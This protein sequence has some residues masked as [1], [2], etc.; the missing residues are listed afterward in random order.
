MARP[1]RS[2]QSLSRRGPSRDSRDRALVVCEGE[3]T[4]PTYFTDMIQSLNL[5]S[6]RVKILGKECGSDPKSVYHYAMKIFEED[7]GYDSLFCVFDKDKHTT[8]DAA[9][10]MIER[11]KLSKDKKIFCIKSV[12][13]FEYWLIL[14]FNSTSAPITS[15]GRRS[16]G[17]NAVLELQKHMSSYQKGASGVYEATKAHLSKAIERSKAV[18]KE[19]ILTG[20]KNPETFVH[21]L[22]EHLKKMAEVK[23]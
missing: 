10:E 2:S 4:E 23:V 15:A 20:S 21:L 9:C 5:S 6:V 16:S 7:G 22:V 18:V 12:P 14:H 11:T 17:E 3:K 8:F 13:C 1:I 19:G